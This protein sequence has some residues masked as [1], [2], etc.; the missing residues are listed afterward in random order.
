MIHSGGDVRIEAYEPGDSGRAVA[1]HHP[2][3]LVA[4]GDG[5][6]KLFYR[7]TPAP[8][9]GEAA[10]QCAE[11]CDPSRRRRIDRGAH[12]ARSGRFTAPVAWQEIGGV[13]HSV[14]VST[15]CGAIAMASSSVEHERRHAVFIDPLLQATY[16]AGRAGDV[17]Y[18]MAVDT[19]GAVLVAGTTASF[20]FP[21]T[22]ARGA[23][24]VANANGDAFVARFRSRTRDVDTRDVRR[25]ER[26]RRMRKRLFVDAYRQRIHRRHHRLPSTFPATAGGAPADGPGRWRRIRRAPHSQP[27]AESNRRRTSAAAH[28]IRRLPA[29]SGDDDNI[30]VCGQHGVRQLPATA[31]WCAGGA[32]GGRRCL[33][34]ASLETARC[35]PYS[36]RRI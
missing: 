31:Q 28:P 9:F 1:R 29:H 35:E 4:R 26:Q 20:D 8:T 23:Q 32:R 19:S 34:S 25:R 30:L 11:R 15:R 16:L 5:V 10:V 33:S 21:G 13:R 24:P 2:S 22:H 36:G 14:H 17:I 3:D 6:E 18:A 27:R 12:R 7:R